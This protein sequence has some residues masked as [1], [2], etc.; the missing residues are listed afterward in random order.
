[1]SGVAI[2][3]KKLEDD[4]TTLE[5]SLAFIKGAVRACEEDLRKTDAE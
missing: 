2:I 5:E 4:G 3:I 1:M